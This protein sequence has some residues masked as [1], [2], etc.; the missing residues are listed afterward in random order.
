MSVRCG[1]DPL[2]CWTVV[3]P[4]AVSSTVFDMTGL[5]LSCDI[6]WHFNRISIGYPI[7]HWLHLN[8]D[9]LSPIVNLLC[10]LTCS[11]KLF[12]DWNVFEFSHGHDGQMKFSCSIQKCRSDSA[13]VNFTS[14]KLHFLTS[15]IRDSSL[16][17]IVWLFR[18]FFIVWF[19]FI[20]LIT[21][22]SNFVILTLAACN[23]TSYWMH[24]PHN[25]LRLK[26]L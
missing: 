22:S 13:A 6:W 3:S 15:L 14:H 21:L 12:V 17:L 11:R 18:V 26:E 2:G 5:I 20:N 24:D 8:K 25:L 16:S 23:F 1:F 19:F 10:W 9:L 7:L 4:L